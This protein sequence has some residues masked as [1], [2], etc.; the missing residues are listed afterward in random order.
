[1]SRQWGVGLVVWMLASSLV[2]AQ[3]EGVTDWS[4]QTEMATAVS[5]VVAAVPVNAGD[6]V[7]RGQL[8]MQLDQRVLRARVDQAQAAVHFQHLQQQE[9]DKE[10]ERAE[11]LYERTLLADHELDLARIDAARARASYQAALAKEQLARQELAQSELRAPFDARVLARHIQPGQTVVTHLAAPAM[12]VLAEA[13]RILVRFEVD[14]EQAAGL[15]NGQALQVEV[16]GQHYPGQIES[17][18]YQGEGARPYL[19]RVGFRSEQALPA[20]LLATVRVP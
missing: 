16:A 14:A 18:H 20:G 2:Q 1:M 19:I 17:I 9:A 11:E 3:W 4:R 13:D 12:L 10:L 6:V 7:K 5:G 8:L 15:S